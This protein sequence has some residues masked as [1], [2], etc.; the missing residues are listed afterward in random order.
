[1]NIKY[2]CGRCGNQ[3][4]LYKE[5]LENGKA[6]ICCLKDNWRSEEVERHEGVKILSDIKKDWE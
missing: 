5:L 2:S 6:I 1:M 4:Y 3:A